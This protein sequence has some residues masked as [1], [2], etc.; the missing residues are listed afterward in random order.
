MRRVVHQGQEGLVPSRVDRR[1]GQLH[2]AQDA[3]DG[4]RHKLRPGREPVVL[5]AGHLHHAA[6]FP[7]E[8][9][10]KGL[11]AALPRGRLADPDFIEDQ[12]EA[13]PGAAARVGTKHR[14][15]ADDVE[16]SGERREHGALRVLFDA[17][18]VDE[19]GGA[20][21]ALGG[22]GAEDGACVFEVLSFF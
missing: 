19:E 9:P 22:Q 16:V 7:F 11:G 6:P 3:A 12:R 15:G 20:P 8:K 5:L 14:V 2:A 21:E 4:V 10:Q 18:D 17:E 1:R 13:G